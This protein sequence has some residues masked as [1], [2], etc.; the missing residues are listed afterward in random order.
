MANREDLWSLLDECG[1]TYWDPLEWLVRSPRRYIG[2]K[3]YFRAIP[4]GSSG[5]LDVEDF[6]VS[7][8]LLPLGSL[9]YLLFCVNKA[10]WGWNSFLE[11]ANAGKGLGFPRDLRIYMKWVLPLLIAFI[12][13]MG[14]KEKFF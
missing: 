12:F 11:E 2:D 13:L 14:Y 3:L 4:E 9:L 8:N 1:M 7:N 6:L 5:V 10:G